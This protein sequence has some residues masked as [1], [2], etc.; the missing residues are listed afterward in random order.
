[1]KR[2]PTG[3]ANKLLKVLRSGDS[4]TLRELSQSINTHKESSVSA[5]L[6]SLRNQFGYNID[7]RP[8]VGKS[9]RYEYFLKRR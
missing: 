8:T 2:K 6:R 3:M 5:S 9:E 1:M 7:K 4:Y